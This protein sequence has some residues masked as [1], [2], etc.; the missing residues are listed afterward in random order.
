MKSRALS[1]SILAT[2]VA[3][4]ALAGCDD[5]QAGARAEL[6]D[7][8]R[9]FGASDTSNDYT[10]T[11][12]RIAADGD[13]GNGTRAMASF[14]VGNVRMQ[15]GLVLLA[16]GPDQ[17]E[18]GGVKGLA[19]LDV[20]AAGVIDELVLR[21]SSSAGT[22]ARADALAQMADVIR[23][24]TAELADKAAAVREA[25]SWAP[26]IGNVDDG[27]P[28]PGIDGEMTDA[29]RQAFDVYVETR[30]ALN[31]SEFDTVATLQGQLTELDEQIVAVQDEIESTESARRES[32]A[33][34]GN[35]ERDALN[36]AGDEALS[37]FRASSNAAMEAGEAGGELIKL[38]SR[39][40]QLQADAENLRTRVG[41]LQEVA[42]EMESRQST[43]EQELEAPDGPATLAAELR[44]E[45]SSA[46]SAVG[47]AVDDLA[48]TLEGLLE[49]ADTLRDEATSAFTSA[50]TNF[51]DAS[52]K[53]GS[54]ASAVSSGSRP[55]GSAVVR[56]LRSTAELA[57]LRH[58]DALRYVAGLS[59]AE[60]V[61][62]L[63]LL[64]LSFATSGSTAVAD[65]TTS[66][67]QD[68]GERF[69]AALQE[70]LTAYEESVTTAQGVAGS[71]PELRTASLR[72]QAL[73]LDGIVSLT[74]LAQAAE[75]MGHQTSVEMPTSSDATARLDT[76]IS[77][78]EA[79]SVQ[80]FA[81]NASR[82]AGT[83]S[84]DDAE[85]AAE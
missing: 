75:L 51:G 82:S 6:K 30:Q 10:G 53:L 31:S 74:R 73:A 62:G 13:T 44:R 43:I 50:A 35:L 76:V 52:S 65:V 78:A 1:R 66:M 24:A 23:S 4:V 40:E 45:A 22:A 32:M 17:G 54:S 19:R 11:L 39:L 72:R 46:S 38:N 47:P 84:S 61:Q 21:A 20:E 85:P 83:S 56:G 79:Q 29:F 3:C 16:D 48:A 70:A 34:S 58:A 28:Y 42:S 64:R 7:A 2:A 14:V 59:Q 68:A 77:D 15:E 12:G 49:E 60:V 57:D 69:D 18:E 63:A 81:Y 80:I 9:A 25:E 33:R 67:T 5:P 8:T 55:A 26:A 71:V 36:K 27:G 41:R 37:A